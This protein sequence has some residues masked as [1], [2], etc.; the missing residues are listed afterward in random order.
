[1]GKR[2]R[3]WGKKKLA[4]LIK[5]LGGKCQLCNSTERLQID[6]PKGREYDPSQMSLDQRVRRYLR[7]ADNGQVRILC[8][9]CNNTYRPSLTKKQALQQ[10]IPD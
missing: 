6:H 5:D 7:D 2:Q 9:Y 4:K 10:V 8:I 3:E 1:M